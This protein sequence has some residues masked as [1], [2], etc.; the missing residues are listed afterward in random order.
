MNCLIMDEITFISCPVIHQ[1]ELE[2]KY[3]WK[4][5]SQIG[6]TDEKFDYGWNYLCCLACHPSKWAWI[7]LWM[8]GGKSDWMNGWMV[9]LWMKL[10]LFPGLPSIKV[11]WHNKNI[12]KTSRIQTLFQK[13]FLYSLIPYKYCIRYF[14]VIS[15]FIEASFFCINIDYSKKKCPI[16]VRKDINNKINLGEMLTLCC[17]TGLT[18]LTNEN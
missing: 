8:K 7:S 16:E 1:S 15:P 12:K 9:W 5:E 2:Q 11:S 3:E 14:I 17:K 6:W 18:V 10:P 13:I 4:W